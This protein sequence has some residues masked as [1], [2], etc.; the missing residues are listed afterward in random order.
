MATVAEDEWTNELDAESTAIE[1]RHD[2]VHESATFRPKDCATIGR[3][4]TTCRDGTFRVSQGLV[5]RSGMASYGR[6]LT[7]ALHQ[8]KRR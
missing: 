8:K 3:I 4:A 2:A 6:D 5:N 7:A 1:R